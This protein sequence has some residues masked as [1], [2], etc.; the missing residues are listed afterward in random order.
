MSQVLGEQFLLLAAA[1]DFRLETIERGSEGIISG[2]ASGHDP[3]EFW[4]QQPGVA[5]REEQGDPQARRCDLIAVA[6]GDALDEAV[7]SG[8][9][10]RSSG[11]RDNGLETEQ[12]QHTEQGLHARIAESQAGRSLPVDLDGPHH[13]IKRVFA[14][15]SIMRYGWDVQQASVGCGT[16]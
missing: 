16:A 11:R 12:H 5:P 3:G 13:L 14:A 6:V 1:V 8:G 15:R 7:Q 9:G 4:A 2:R 10:R